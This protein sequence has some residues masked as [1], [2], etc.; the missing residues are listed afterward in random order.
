MGCDDL[1]F[2]EIYLEMNSEVEEALYPLLQEQGIQGWNWIDKGSRGG[3]LFYLPANRSWKE[4]VERIK[5]KV[6]KLR[7]FGLEPGPVSF[8]YKDIDSRSWEKKIKQASEPRQ[9][10]EGFWVVPPEYREEDFPEGLVIRLRGGMAFGTGDHPST[11]LAL[12]FIRD[13]FQNR[14]KVLDLGTGSG[15]L[16]LAAAR[17]GAGKIIGIDNDPEAVSLARENVGLN[18]LSD[19]VTIKEGDL[20]QGIE[21]SFS[22]VIINILYP[23]IAAVLPELERITEKNAGLILSGILFKQLPML[24]E[25]ISSSVWEVIDTR[26]EGD[27][28]GLY[29][30]KKG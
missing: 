23:Q 22:G 10:L 24:R 7:E 19:R 25:K 11:R 12:G 2:K 17:L 14:E 21:N 4:R 16:A 9:V 29:L 26:I 30:E 8:N 15:I 5:K 1:K 27:W 6:E 13:W 20:L 3:C 28:A 18:G